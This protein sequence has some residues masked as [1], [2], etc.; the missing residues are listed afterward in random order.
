MDLRK[1][2]DPNKKRKFSEPTLDLFFKK[3]KPN[4]DHPLIALIQ[5]RNRKDSNTK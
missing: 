1:E 4:T 5:K 2:E 3:I